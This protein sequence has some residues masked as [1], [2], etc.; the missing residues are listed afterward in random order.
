MNTAKTYAE[1]IA[2]DYA[3]K[4]TS[5]LKALKKLDRKA[6]QM[7][8]FVSYTHGIVC[9]L[10]LGVGMCFSLNIIGG[11][12]ALFLALGGII[13]AFLTVRFFIQL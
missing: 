9:T 4:E 12:T 2:T 7:A 13:G 10:L 8:N 6:K 3:P 1:K 11:G 5:D